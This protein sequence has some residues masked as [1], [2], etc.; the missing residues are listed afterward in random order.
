MEGRWGAAQWKPSPNFGYPKGAHGRDGQHIRGI[1]F[2]RAEGSLQAACSTF[3]DPAPD[4]DPTRAVSAHIIFGKGGEI[5]QFVDFNDAAWHA[6]IIDHPIDLPGWYLDG[7]N[8]NLK[9]LGIETEGTHLEPLTAIQVSQLNRFL[10]WVMPQTGLPCSYNCWLG[11]YRFDSINRLN[12]PGPLF[13][14][15]TLSFEVLPTLDLKADEAFR[16]YAPKTH[17]WPEVAENLL[18][19]ANDALQ[20]GRALAAAC[21]EHAQIWG[22]R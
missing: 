20:A 12:C 3:A 16:Q 10:R 1:V 15:A 13:P 21:P 19:V 6:G 9:T 8:P 2:H 7:G 11:H 18:G 22:A 14:W 17:S 4:G 5:V